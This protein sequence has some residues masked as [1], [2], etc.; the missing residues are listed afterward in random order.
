MTLSKSNNDGMIIIKEKSK[1]IGRLF[2]SGK[3]SVENYDKFN[4]KMILSVT[5]PLIIL[6]GSIDTLLKNVT[7]IDYKID[8]SICAWIPRIDES[9]VRTE[10]RAAISNEVNLKVQ[11]LVIQ[12]LSLF[13]ECSKYCYPADLVPM[14]PLGIYVNFKILGKVEDIKTEQNG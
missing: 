9:R 4:D 11:D 5:I 12:V 8:E 14:L 6:H 2:G 1:G 7:V 10:G 3:I 13:K